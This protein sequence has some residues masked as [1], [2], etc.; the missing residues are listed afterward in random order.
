M[1]DCGLGDSPRRRGGAVEDCSRQATSTV[2]WL[3]PVAVEHAE[4]GC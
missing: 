4:A 2:E 1:S 3:R